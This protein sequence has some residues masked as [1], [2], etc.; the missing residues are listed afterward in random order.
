MT[1]VTDDAGD[2][3]RWTSCYFGDSEAA[4]IGA[5]DN[6]G[7]VGF[8]DLHT[9][10]PVFQQ[11]YNCRD[12]NG[13]G[14]RLDPWTFVIEGPWRIVDVAFEDVSTERDGGAIFIAISS[15]YEIS[16]CSFKSCQATRSDASSGAI[17]VERAG[18]GSFIADCCGESCFAHRSGF[19]SLGESG[20]V[21]G[22]TFDYN[23]QNEGGCL[24]F[25]GVFDQVDE[26]EAEIIRTNFS[27]CDS[28]YEHAV[29]SYE[30]SGVRLDGCMFADA[31]V[32]S[33]RVFYVYSSRLFCVG[34]HFVNN[35]GGLLT[36]DDCSDPV[37]SIWF[38]FDGC[39]FRNTL[40][41][42][43]AGGGEKQRWNECFW[44]ED[45]AVPTDCAD[46]Q[47]GHVGNTNWT[48]HVN[49]FRQPQVCGGWIAA[50][51][52]ALLLESEL[53][54]TKEVQT[55]LAGAGVRTG[56][57]PSSANR[58]SVLIAGSGLV[59]TDKQETEFAAAGAPTA[60]ADSREI[61]I[62]EATPSHGFVLSA[63]LTPT[64]R[65]T[66]SRTFVPPPSG[67]VSAMDTLSVT[68]TISLSPEETLVSELTDVVSWTFADGTWLNVSN[69]WTWSAISAWFE[70]P[71]QTVV[72]RQSLIY[73]TF[74]FAT[75]QTIR[76]WFSY[77]QLAPVIPEGGWSNGMIIGFITGA[78][79][80]A[81][82]AAALVALTRRRKMYASGNAAVWTTSGSGGDADQDWGN[83]LEGECSSDIE[84]AKVF[85]P[86]AENASVIGPVVDVP[87]THDRADEPEGDQTAKH[88]PVMKT[89]VI[90][91][92]DIST[93]ESMR[94]KADGPAPEAM[95]LAWLEQ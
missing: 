69:V 19:A 14:I 37:W 62:P 20:D 72:W 93:T 83:E 76:V 17:C 81:A 7:H 35:P 79:A 88:V 77:E 38:T 71:S 25:T 48:T 66:R 9:F 54:V 8:T 73:R 11:R 13:D 26:F 46:D 29:V 59:A 4:P 21:I 84:T 67:A 22:C 90:D 33:S 40:I 95:D 70:V 34:C 24:S 82:A 51:P 52:T 53:V 80:V 64:A 30:L 74:Y 18:T 63:L 1:G 10:V 94:P 27:K 92:H 58:A 23:A 50:I 16:R 15:G 3:C 78:L 49:N 39:Y 44:F 43:A 5:V 85:P 42:P 89:F 87:L 28:T 65:F 32:V 31:V 57:A 68:M 45:V 61:T 75:Y 56:F 91:F 12:H 55:E 36:E 47:G 41:N 6:G 60:L 86:L 2:A